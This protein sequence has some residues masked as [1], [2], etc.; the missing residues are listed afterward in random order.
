MANAGADRSQPILRLPVDR[1]SCSLLLADGTRVNG[2]LFR[3]PGTPVVGLLDEPEPFLPLATDYGVRLL[4]R[5]LIAAVALPPA[6]LDADELPGVHQQAVVTLRSGQRLR[7]ELRWT[8]APGHARTIDLL[9]EPG[10]ALLLHGDVV[11]LIARAH[12]AW[13]EDK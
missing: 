2:A 12:I 4:A 7:G 6:P 13:V 3:T 1:I 11:H 8:P 5:A 9:N 10:A